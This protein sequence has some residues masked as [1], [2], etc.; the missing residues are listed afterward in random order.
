MDP[1]LCSEGTEH[2]LFLDGFWRQAIVPYVSMLFDLGSSRE[3]KKMDEA[4]T[5]QLDRILW[6]QQN[7]K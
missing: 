7:F 1:E 2:G 5:E 4:A 6:C 3:G